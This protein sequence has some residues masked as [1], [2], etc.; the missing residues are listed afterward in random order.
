MPDT[1]PPSAHPVI[2]CMFCGEPEHVEILEIW[3]HEWMFETCCEGLH[4]QLALEMSEDP[5]W[6]R[7]LLRTLDLEVLCGRKLRRVTDDGACGLILDW[8]LEIRR[9]R[10]RVHQ[11]LYRSSTTFIAGC[12]LPGA[13]IPGSITAARCWALPWSEIPSPRR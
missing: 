9:D 2:P 13:F 8:A 11:A 12:P 3:D 4:E 10:P 7:R 1:V 5:E 6:A